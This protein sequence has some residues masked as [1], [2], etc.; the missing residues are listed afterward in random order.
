LGRPFDVLTE[1]TVQNYKDGGQTL[2]IA[3]PNSTQRC[4]LPTYE[5]GR[6]PVVM[7]AEIPKLPEDFRSSMN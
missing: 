7:K 2:I 3:D 1:S 5:R 6:P 4:V